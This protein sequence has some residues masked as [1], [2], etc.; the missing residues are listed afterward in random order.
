MVAPFIQYEHGPSVYECKHE[1]AHQS[2]GSGGTS[3]YPAI[4]CFSCKRH[5]YH[6]HLYF[7]AWEEQVELSVIH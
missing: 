6:Y 3:Q 4:L 2:R 7:Y 5:A 1:Q